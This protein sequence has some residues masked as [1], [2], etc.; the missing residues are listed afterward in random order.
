MLALWPYSKI[1]RLSQFFSNTN[2]I[3]NQVVYSEG[4]ETKAVYVIVS[5]EFKLSKKLDIP[6]RKRLTLTKTKR[7]II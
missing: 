4:D 7:K 5:G 2:Y 3:R 1:V 6:Q